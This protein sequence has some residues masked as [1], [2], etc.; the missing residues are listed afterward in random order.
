[1]KRINITKIFVSYFVQE[2]YLHLQ[3][4]YAQKRDKRSKKFNFV[5]LILFKP[6]YCTSFN[7][8]DR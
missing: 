2:I 1:M 6:E 4:D 3:S 5:K 8:S 7:I